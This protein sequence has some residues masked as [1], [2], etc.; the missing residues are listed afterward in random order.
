MSGYCFSFIHTS[1]VCRIRGRALF[2]ES[3]RK[4]QEMKAAQKGHR[5]SCGPDMSS[6]R[7]SDLELLKQAP[8]PKAAL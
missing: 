1:E 5:L 4:E 2:L 7:E 6:V 8:W 3:K